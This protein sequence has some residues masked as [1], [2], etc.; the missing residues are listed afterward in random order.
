MVSQCSR[1]IQA[2]ALHGGVFDQGNQK[3]DYGDSNPVERGNIQFWGRPQ[4]PTK[5]TPYEKEG[6]YGTVHSFSREEDGLEV[7]VPQIYDG[8]WHTEDE[9]WQ[10]YKDTGQHMGKFKDYKDA[11]KFGEKYH[12]D[13][14]AGKYDTHK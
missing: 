7:L 4:V 10:H 14:A 12:L 8:K 6:K 9:A 3:V 13:A 2:K 1:Q 5:G 11:D